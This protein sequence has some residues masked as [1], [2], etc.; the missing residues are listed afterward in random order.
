MAT[1]LCVTMTTILYVTMTTIYA[2]HMIFWFL[3]DLKP[4]EYPDGTRMAAAYNK[5]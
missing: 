5:A 4:F 2:S 1:I 3:A